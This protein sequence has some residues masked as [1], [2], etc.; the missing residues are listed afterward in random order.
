LTTSFFPIFRRKYEQFQGKNS[1]FWRSSPQNLYKIKA[2]D[3]FETRLEQPLL[4]KR[5]KAR[6]NRAIKTLGLAIEQAN[7][8]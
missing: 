7:Y 4:V 5:S 6:A 2:G 8:Y 1:P 3:Q